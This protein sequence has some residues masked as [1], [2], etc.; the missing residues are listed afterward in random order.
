[1]SSSDSA[2]DIALST[3]FHRDV[4]IVTS[5]AV[6]STFGVVTIRCS[7]EV[8]NLFYWM[9]WLV[10]DCFTGKSGVSS[11]FCTFS[12]FSFSIFVETTVTS[13]L[14]WFQTNILKKVLFSG[15]GNGEVSW[16][17]SLLT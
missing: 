13:L 5:V 10:G 9:R 4:L 2:G 12:I 11:I 3:S 17:R 1:M 15:L 8:T 16:K 6:Q 14:T 7:M